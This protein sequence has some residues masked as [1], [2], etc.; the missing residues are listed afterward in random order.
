MIKR[1]LLAWIIVGESLN[2]FEDLLFL[3]ELLLVLHGL[4]FVFYTSIAE[5]NITA[6]ESNMREICMHDMTSV[7]R[8][9]I[10]RARKCSTFLSFVYHLRVL[11]HK[12][13]LSY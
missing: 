12:V 6:K 5:Q 10:Y 4:F 11:I 9:M 3:L 13:A 1:S 7:V 8:R 2:G